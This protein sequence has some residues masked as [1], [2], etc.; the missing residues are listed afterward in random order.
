MLRQHGAGWGGV[1]GDVWSV[2]LYR[3]WEG[4]SVG[5]LFAFIG[6]AWGVSCRIYLF[7]Y[8]NSEVCYSLNRSVSVLCWQYLLY[9]NLLER[10]PR[11]YICFIIPSKQFVHSQIIIK[12]LWMVSL[13]EQVFL[14]PIDSIGNIP[15]ARWK[16]TCYICK[17]RGVGACIQC[18][19]ANCYTGWCL[20]AVQQ[21]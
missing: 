13:I 6:R 10:Y 18:N 12:Y 9:F 15:A 1:G 20:Y 14:E 11:K 3:G 21:G 2:Y 8:L 19:K 7:T 17:Q 16:L 4:G 5:V